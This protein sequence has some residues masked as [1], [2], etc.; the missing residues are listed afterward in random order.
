M[1]EFS[2]HNARRTAIALAAIY[3]AAVAIHI[4]LLWHA[5]LSPHISSDELQYV[6]T[7]EN[8]G[9][10][11]GFLLRGRFNSSLPPFYPLFVAGAHSLGTEPRET[12]FFLNCLATGPKVTFVAGAAWAILSPRLMICPFP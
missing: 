2:L 9:S 8:I 6:G 5:S 10:G 1:G 11:R 7:A 12:A 3:A 4:A